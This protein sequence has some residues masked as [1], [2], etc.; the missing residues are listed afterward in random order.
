MYNCDMFKIAFRPTPLFIGSN[1]CK[2]MNANGLSLGIA[3]K[4]VHSK[5]DLQ[6][7]D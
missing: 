7:S 3:S 1:L 5:K 2:G 6:S 4:V